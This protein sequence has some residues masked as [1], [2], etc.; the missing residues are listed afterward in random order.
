MSQINIPS[1]VEK[2]LNLLNQNNFEAY[3]VGGC[4][5]DYLIGNL[6]KDWD[7]TTNAKPE[8]IKNIFEKTVDTGIAHGTVTIILNKK[9]FEVTTYRIDGEYKDCRKPQN[10]FFT[11]DLIKDLSRRDFTINAIAYNKINGYVDPFDGRDDIKNKLIRCVADTNLRFK[12]DALRM[13]RALR[14]ACQLNFNIENETYKKLCENVHLIEFVSIERIRDELI[15][16][17]SS[18]H[19]NNFHL[20]IDSKI[21][22]YVS[23]D[24]HRYLC[25]NLDCIKKILERS[26]KKT[27]ILFATAFYKLNSNLAYKLMKFFRFDNKTCDTVKIILDNLNVSF[28]NDCYIIKKIISKI[29]YERFCF[30]IEVQE[31]LSLIDSAN[32]IKK[33]ADNMKNECIFLK[34]LAL[35]GNDIKALG[36]SGAKIGLVLNYL[37]DIVHKFPC[38]NN[39]DEL[40]ALAKLYK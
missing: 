31:N 38:K 25:D 23:L 34:D 17:F 40:I 20:L 19:L 11:D 1:E 29:G 18:S 22:K 28:E 10:V 2:I 7:I 15:K 27:D 21:L 13:M 30:L 16:L 12:E 39:F 33:L 8:Q 37:L 6:P 3:V 24:L 35:N 14:F 4:V 36:F 9:H 5:R 32:D 26:N